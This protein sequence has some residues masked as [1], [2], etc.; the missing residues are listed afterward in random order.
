MAGADRVEPLQLH[1]VVR[2]DLHPARK[3]HPRGEMQIVPFHLPD[4]GLYATVVPIQRRGGL[5]V[6]VRLLAAGARQGILGRAADY[7][8]GIHQDIRHLPVGDA[9][10]LSAF[11]AQ[12]GLCRA[13]RHCVPAGSGGQHA[14]VGTA[15]LLRSM[16]RRPDRTP[17]H[18][19][20][21]ERLLSASARTAPLPD[22]CPD[23]RA[24][25]IGRRRA[26]QPAQLATALLPDNQ[27]RGADGLCH[28]VQQLERGAHLL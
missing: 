24:G 14:A 6:P 20:M 27:P 3:V 26:G 2:G 15:R 7:D 12:R 8:F 4:T 19:D 5:Y 25:S 21:D 1:A 10:V 9:A 17:G 13:D 22:V 28:P 18:P 23:R 16:G 11:L